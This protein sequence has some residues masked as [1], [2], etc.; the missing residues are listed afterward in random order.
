M[1]KVLQNC[2]YIGEYRHGDIVVV[3]GMPALVDEET[4]DKVQR[5]FAVNK[6]KGS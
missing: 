3:G 1:N 6:R 5:K 2:A 4:F